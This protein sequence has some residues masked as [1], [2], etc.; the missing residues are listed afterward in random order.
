VT[1]ILV[2]IVSGACKNL[3][4][5]MKCRIYEHRPLVCR[6]YPAEI[7]PFVQFTT[8]AKACPPEAWQSERLLLTDGQPVDPGLQSM[9]ERSRQTDRDEA[10][11]KGLLCSD[12]GI[13]VSGIAHEGFVAHEPERHL[14]LH[15]MRRAAGADIS[16]PP[17]Q[18]MWR[19]YSREPETL[20]SLAAGGFTTVSEKGPQDSFTFLHAPRPTT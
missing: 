19:L 12:L 15:A 7:S 14:L 20:T 18:P 6:I 17:P 2:G 13:S 3:G 8:T 16:S 11:K 1:A 4:E 10:L 9:I 5:D